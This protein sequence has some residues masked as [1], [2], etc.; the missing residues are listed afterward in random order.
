MKYPTVQ[1]T[2]ETLQLNSD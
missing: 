1:R 2:D